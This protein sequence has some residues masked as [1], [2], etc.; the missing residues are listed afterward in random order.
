MPIVFVTALCAN[1]AKP[2]PQDAGGS[3]SFV[4]FKQHVLAIAGVAGTI[5]SSKSFPHLDISTLEGMRSQSICLL[6]F[7]FASI[8]HTARA[9]CWCSVAHPFCCTH[10]VS[11]LADA[12]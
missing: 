4:T 5:C 7:K 2:V 3:T 9:A 6:C 8:A 10:S 12:A 1:R 11:V